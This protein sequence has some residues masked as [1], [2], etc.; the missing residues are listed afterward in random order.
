M[1]KPR[2]RCTSRELTVVLLVPQAGDLKSGVFLGF[3]VYRKN[4]LASCGVIATSHCALGL[5]WLGP[6]GPWRVYGPPV[7]SH[8]YRNNL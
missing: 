1:T 5:H 6:C 4:R 3:V 8:T 2:P 7:S